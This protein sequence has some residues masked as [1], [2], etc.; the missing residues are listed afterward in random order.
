VRRAL[1]LVLLL[2]ACR[3]ANTGD[4]T[5]RFWT[6]GREGEAVRAMIPAFER[7]HPGIHVRTQQIPFTAAHEK[8]LTAYVGDAM[9]DVAQIGNTWIA[10]FAA[11]HALMPLNGRADSADYYPG[12][13]GTNLIGDTLYGVPWYVDTRVVFYRSDMLAA[14]GYRSMPTSWGAW[15]AA[16]RQIRVNEGGGDRFAIL[17]P[18]SE[19]ATPVILGLEEGAPLL[20]DDGQYG[21]FNEPRFRQAFDYYV[22]LFRDSLAPTVNAAQVANRYQSFAAGDFAMTVTGPWDIGEFSHRLP[23]SLDGKWMTAPMPAPDGVA[24]PGASI[25]GGSSLVIFRRSAHPEAAWALIAFLSQPAEQLEFYRLTGDLPP[26]QSAWSDSSLAR[27]Q[28]AAAFRAQLQHLAPLP[29]VPEIEQIVT[30]FAQYAEAVV[31]GAMTEDAA[32]AAL[33]RD[34]DRLLEKRRWLLAQGAHGH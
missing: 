33:D 34:V 7:A 21:N 20:R 4:V 29:K 12:I 8:L 19:W 13:W 18:V 2:A 14:A 11:L 1:A 6:V 31:R 3:Q 32:L 26:R 5:I 10:E 23:P 17:L 27:N 9:P 28:Y 25:A 24:P 30:M 16:M 15:R 22:G